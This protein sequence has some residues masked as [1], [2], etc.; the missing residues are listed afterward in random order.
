MGDSA[1]QQRTWLDARQTFQDSGP[2]LPNS[3]GPAT[4]IPL[5]TGCAPPVVQHLRTLSGPATTAQWESRW[6]LTNCLLPRPLT[7]LWASCPE[8]SAQAWE[9]TAAQSL[10]M[11]SSGR[12]FPCLLQLGL[13]VTFHRLATPLWK[14]L[15]L[16]GSSGFSELGFP[17]SKSELLPRKESSQTTF[18]LHARES[19]QATHQRQFGCSLLVSQRGGVNLSTNKFPCKLS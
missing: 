7:R 12:D 10:L 17:K 5:R 9:T 15:A 14:A 19:A 1:Q 13:M 18:H 16:P 8:T 3:S 4:G 6:R 2:P 11:W